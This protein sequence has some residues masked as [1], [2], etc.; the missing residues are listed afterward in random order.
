ALWLTRLHGRAVS[1]TR[2]ADPPRPRL[3]LMMVVLDPGP[4][5]LEP[6]IA[7]R[8]DAMLQAGF[9]AEVESLHA[10]GYDAETRAM[11][12]LGYRQMLDVVEG[13]LTVARAR[14]A[15]V[16][17]TRQYAKRQRTFYRG[18]LP[19]ERV[20]NIGCAA[21]CPW[22]AIQAFLSEPARRAP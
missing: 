3:R 1:D 6:R 21:D 16:V 19:A 4:A 10:A 12:S 22:D 9:L 7:A 20:V 5:A 2:A 14:D 8:L 11:R 17:A 18:Q 13:R 15:I